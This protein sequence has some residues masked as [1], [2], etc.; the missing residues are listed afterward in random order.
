MSM[1]S[2]FKE[3]VTKGN[4]MDMATGIIIGAAV[5]AVVGSIV[6]D[7]IMP[8]IGLLTGGVDFSHLSIALGEGEKAAKFGYGAFIQALINFLIISFVIFMIIKAVNSMKKKEEAAPS[9]VPPEDVL[10]LREI[11]DSL[12]K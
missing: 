3:F 7:L 1:V 9:S 8:I 10:L 12:K 6:D 4:M 5:T 11:R 2:E